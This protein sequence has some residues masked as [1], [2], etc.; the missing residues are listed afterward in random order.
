MLCYN[1]KCDDRVGQY[2]NLFY[3]RYL[4]NSISIFMTGEITWLLS[5]VCT[6]SLPRLVIATS[7][8]AEA[9]ELV[10]LTIRRYSNLLKE[11]RQP[12]QWGRRGVI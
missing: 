8:M 12:T 7:Q 6:L 1:C 2:I 10:D 9:L 4:P 3:S 5:H 11:I